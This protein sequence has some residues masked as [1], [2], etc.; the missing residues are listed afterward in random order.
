LSAA[1]ESTRM[2]RAIARYRVQ[3]GVRLVVEVGHRDRAGRIT[4]DQLVDRPASGSDR[5][6][7][8]EPDL[9]AGDRLRGYVAEYAARRRTWGAA[10]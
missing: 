6:Y 4:I 10:R 7:L 2:Q 9:R 8:V 1:E 3:E 5:S